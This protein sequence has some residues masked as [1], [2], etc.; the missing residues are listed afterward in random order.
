MDLKSFGQS[1]DRILG[2]C[3]ERCYRVVDEERR[4]RKT[5]EGRKQV[6]FDSVRKFLEEHLRPRLRFVAERLPQ[7]GFPEGVLPL[8]LELHLGRT[9]RYPKT[10]QL[11]IRFSADDAF[12]KAAI[13]WDG[14]L[15][16]ILQGDP[17]VPPAESLEWSLGSDPAPSVVP[18]V[19]ERLLQFVQAYLRTQKCDAE[20]TPL[21]AEARDTPVS[22]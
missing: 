15:I 5:L 18:W 1:V 21:P 10:G 8:E 11:K 3:D 20:R 14:Y 12:A 16:P 9:E 22:P 2:T 4:R 17:P 6:F 13:H 7:A 19:E